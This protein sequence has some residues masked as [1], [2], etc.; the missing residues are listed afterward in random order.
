MGR[1]SRTERQRTPRFDLIGS[2]VIQVMGNGVDGIEEIKIRKSD[3]T[4]IRL[5]CGCDD[6][7]YI[8]K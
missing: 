7:I 5:A 3:G 8:Q 1:I 2:T 4:I 6:K